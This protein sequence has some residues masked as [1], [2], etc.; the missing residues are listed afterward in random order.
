LLHAV[1]SFL[2]R[3][4][5]CMFFLKACVCARP[6]DRLLVRVCMKC[7]GNGLVTIVLEPNSMVAEQVFEITGFML[8]I[9][10][11]CFKSL[12]SVTFFLL[13]SLDS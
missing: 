12:D 4:E 6:R 13:K 2:A 10:F 3:Y 8:L 11:Y 1:A 7:T 9:F 5:A